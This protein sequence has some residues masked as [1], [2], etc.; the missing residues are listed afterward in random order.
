MC[1]Y[2]Q[3]NKIKVKNNACGIYT[4]RLKSDKKKKITRKNHQKIL[5]FFFFLYTF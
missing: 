2:T 3:V 4:S 1:I 5:L